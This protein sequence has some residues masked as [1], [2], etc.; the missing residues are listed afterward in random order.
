MRTLFFL[1]LIVPLIALLAPPPFVGA[2]VMGGMVA[3]AEGGT[4][5]VLAALLA[6]VVGPI[7]SFLIAARRFSGKIETTEASDL[8]EESRAIRDWSMQ[9]IN[10]L[11]GVVARLEAR[12]E[13]LELERDQLHREVNTLRAE[14]IELRA[15]LDNGVGS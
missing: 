10:A 6:A 8:W 5:A 11:Q 12:L 14:N 2:V 1:S 4:F 7:L 13:A 15:R 3:V 9:R